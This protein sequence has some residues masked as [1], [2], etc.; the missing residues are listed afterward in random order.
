MKAESNVTLACETTIRAEINAPLIEQAVSNLLENA[1]KYSPEGS[2]VILSCDEDDEV[3]CIKVC[4][5][6]SGIGADHLPR[7]FER[8]YRVDK[9]RSRQMGGTGL[10]LAIVKHITQAHNGRVSVTSEL[11]VGSTFTIILPR[12]A[13]NEDSSAD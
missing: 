9:A 2:P 6:G 5:T 4:D 1:L 12:E 13:R 7:L 11:G 3:T 8:F 10:G